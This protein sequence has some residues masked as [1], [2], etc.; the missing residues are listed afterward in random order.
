MELLYYT[1]PGQRFLQQDDLLSPFI[2]KADSPVLTTTTGVYNAIYGMQAWVQ[3]NQEANTF[4]VLPKLPWTRSGWRVITAR[5]GSLPQGGVAETAA[6]PD[7]I[8]PTFAEVETKPKISAD[9]FE[10]SE[11]QEFLATQGGD[12]AFGR[13]ADLR[14]YMGVQ[15]KEDINV[16]LNTQNGTLA[17]N[18][19]ESVDRVAAN[20]SEFAGNSDSGGSAYSS[21]DLDIYTVGAG[22]VDRDSSTW[23]DAYVNHNSGTDRSLTD[24]ILQAL[25]QNTLANGANPEGQFIQTGYDSWAT[26]NQLY[27]TQVRYNLIGSATI[28]PGVNGIKTLEG[29]AV[30]TNVA[31]LYNRPVILTKNTV[32]D[33]ISRVYLLDTSNP[34]GFDY[35]RLFL[36]IAKPTQYFEAGMNQGTP[37][38]VDKFGTQ[39]MY[40]TMGE[41]IC[42]FFAAQGKARDLKA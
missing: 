10:N 37:F 14:T 42:T 25:V 38:A 9:V 30:G 29:R 28:Q 39:G 3:L 16:Q 22:N 24:S 15:H 12:D 20:N 41:I 6:L 31:T 5:A 36:K 40:R 1:G 34:E 2:A 27:D 18:N 11:M 33:S 7:S 8:Q 26:I 23:G 21:G 35:P 17:S 19:F 4:G 13:M 32:Q